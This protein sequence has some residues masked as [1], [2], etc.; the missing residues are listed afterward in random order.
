MGEMILDSNTDSYL[1]DN[2]R[3][4]MFDDNSACDEL[5]DSDTTTVSLDFSVLI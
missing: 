1:T 4:K 2:R 3:V 5:D